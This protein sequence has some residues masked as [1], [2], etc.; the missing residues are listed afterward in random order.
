MRNTNQFKLKHLIKFLF[1]VTTMTSLIGCEKTPLS[2]E[3]SSTLTNDNLVEVKFPEVEQ[4]GG[5]LGVSYQ[6]VAQAFK[7]LGTEYYVKA[8]SKGN[9]NI[10]NAEPEFAGK[11]ILICSMM[12]G[13]YLD[14]AKDVVEACIAGQR[15]DGYLGMLPEGEELTNFSIWNQTFTILGLVEYYNQTKDI[16]ALIA[17]TKSAMHVKKTLIDSVNNGRRITDALNGGTQHISAIISFARLYKATNDKTF[18]DFAIYMIEKTEQEDFN[19]LNFDSLF[20]V[21]SQKGIEMLVIYLGIIEVAQ[22]IKEKN[23][24]CSLNSDQ[25]LDK[26]DLYWDLVYQTQIR[27]TGGGTTGEWWRPNG[28]TPAL[29]KTSD[30]VNENCVSVGWLELSLSLFFTNPHAK[31]LEAIEKTFYNAILGSMATDGSDFAYYQGNYGRKEFATSGGMYKCCRTRGFNAIATLPYM[32]YYYDNENIIP[33]IYSQGSYETNDGLK[34]A[35]ESSYPSEGLLTYH[36][37]NDTNTT[38]QMKLRIPGWCDTY[39][40]KVNDSKTNPDIVD[41]YITI[42]LPNGYSKVTLNLDMEL[43]SYKHEINK[44]KYIE[45][46]YGPLLMVHDRHN[47][48]TLK[49]AVYN[50]NNKIKKVDTSLWNKWDE[51]NEGSWYLVQY[52]CGN[53]NLVD[54][55]SA[56]RADIENDMF[57]TYIRREEE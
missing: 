57:S 18:L 39:V 52:T 51:N 14:L 31:Y 49:K 5:I 20:D 42:Q 37:Q 24:Q 16:N 28:N 50:S 23:I 47:G 40:V 36:V 12:G 44:E 15:E 55:A 34:V 45:F 38:K 7:D 9:P 33:I 2:N 29:L 17:A 4:I 46:R 19:L 32:M 25:V 54:Y 56:C 41:G 8:Y 26:V 1:V 22:I 53:L 43:V 48:T 11:Y 21:R 35:C 10:W 3:T 27:N 6:K 30:A 13:E